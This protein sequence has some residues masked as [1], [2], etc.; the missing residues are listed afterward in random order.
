VHRHRLDLPSPTRA[1]AK[2][3][4][5]MAYTQVIRSHH[6][7]Y[8]GPS[9]KSSAGRAGCGMTQ[10][11]LNGYSKTSNWAVVRR[12]Q[13]KLQTTVILVRIARTQLGAGARHASA[14]EIQTRATINGCPTLE[15][16]FVI[17]TTDD[18]HP[19]I[20]NPQR[21]PSRLLDQS[22]L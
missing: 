16:C 18:V 13:D 17:Y 9:G 4:S 20:S 22:Q 21:D 2:A 1:P 6:T 8:Y 19:R 7:E 11:N 5:D 3:G 15:L 10:R 12:V 14:S